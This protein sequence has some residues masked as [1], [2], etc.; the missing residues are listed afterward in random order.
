MSAEILNIPE[1]YKSKSH[2]IG[3]IAS[4]FNE[5][6]M[7]DLLGSTLKELKVLSPLS[8]VD[9]YRSPGSLEIPIITKKLAD[10]GEH[11]V[12]ICLGLIMEGG[13]KHGDIMSRSLT[14]KILDISIEYNLPI[15][16]EILIVTTQEQAEA[17]CSGTEINRGVE[18]ARAALI[19]LDTLEKL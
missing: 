4:L 11:D 16:N 8:T 15:V 14:P 1:E 12:L 10:R 5:S 7:S 2:K 6:L 19:V 18:A 9:V 13:T 17:R 3:I